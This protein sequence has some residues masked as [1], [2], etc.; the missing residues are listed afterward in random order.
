MSGFLFEQI[1]FGPIRS[2]RLGIS[3]G[4]NL[5][6]TARKHC[7]FNCLYCECGWTQTHLIEEGFPD[8]DQIREALE[9][10]LQSMVGKQALLDSITFAGN[11]E[12]TIHPQFAQ[13][14]DDVVFL[15]NRY[16]PEAK[17]SVLTNASTTADPL[18]VQALLK[19]DQPILKLDA[20]TEETFRRINNPCINI[21]LRKIIESMAPLKGKAI[22]QTLF[23]T[24]THG[25]KPI[26][27]TSNEEIDAWL[28]HL[29]FIQPSLVMIYPIVRSTP[30]ENLQ[31]V[32]FDT[33]NAI[34]AKVEA[35]GFT[36][37]VY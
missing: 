28:K 9:N 23:V 31:V 19:T 1:I 13:I 27:N 14:V 24:G 21:S 20:G 34:A 12:P 35:L 6:P 32:P 26:D 15:R 29:Q 8:A 22:I 4:V 5:L 25:G 17:V 30:E 18:I 7:T 16:Y 11:G 10:K 2:R 33:L 3:L 36:A 37:Q